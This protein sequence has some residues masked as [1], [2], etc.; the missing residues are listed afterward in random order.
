MNY[1]KL[2]AAEEKAIFAAGCFWGVEYFFSQA[3][4]VRQTTVATSAAKQG[5]PPTK[6]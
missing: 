5:I 2:T 3:K 1:G 4:G 6:R